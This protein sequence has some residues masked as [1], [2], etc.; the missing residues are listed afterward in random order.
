MDGV[1]CSSEKTCIF[2]TGAD[3]CQI[4][5]C[6]DKDKGCSMNSSDCSFQNAVDKNC[7]SGTKYTHKNGSYEVSGQPGDSVKCPSTPA[8]GGTSGTTTTSTAPNGS[9]ITQKGPGDASSSASPLDK[10]TEKEL[11]DFAQKCGFGNDA[12]K[13]IPFYKMGI[14][15]NL[16]TFRVSLLS[17]PSVRSQ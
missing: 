3:K 6:K 1:N 16:S 8:E 10:M 11:Q 2:S 15:E 7:I 12:T 4:G 5:L 13:D 14:G 9:T 17:L